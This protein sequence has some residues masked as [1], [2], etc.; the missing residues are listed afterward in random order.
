MSYINDEL[1]ILPDEV[2]PEPDPF[3]VIIKPKQDVLISYPHAKTD[4]TS[5]SFFL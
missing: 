1:M 3:I 4:A 5:P 2:E